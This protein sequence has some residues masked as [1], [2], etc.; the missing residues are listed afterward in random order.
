MRPLPLNPASGVKPSVGSGGGSGSVPSASPP[1]WWLLV[2]LLGSLLALWACVSL[3]QQRLAADPRLAEFAGVSLIPASLDDISRSAAYIARAGSLHAVPV[4]LVW[5]LAY[6]IKMAFSLPGGM[7]LNVFA[8]VAFGRVVGVLST[9]ALS[10]V[11]ASGAFLVSLT[12][13]AALISRCGCSERI[14]P[15][16]LRIGAARKQRSLFFYITALRMTFAFPQWLLNLS[17]P[18][19]GVPLPLFAACTLVG[20]LPF[21]TTTVSVGAT[22]AELSASGGMA[23]LA[24]SSIFSPSVV[25]GTLALAGLCVIPGLAMRRVEARLGLQSARLQSAPESAAATASLQHGA[26]AS[27]AAAASEAVL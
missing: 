13:G 6:V 27:P 11:G 17:A 12:W 8:G 26:R 2:L 5:S 9:A 16:R 22:L 24:L 20:S 15:L 18:H 7:A 4:W 1:A 3:L 19:V 23:N 10:A 14:L 25:L 21:C